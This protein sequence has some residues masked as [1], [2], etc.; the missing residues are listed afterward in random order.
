MI[1]EYG[2]M[3]NYY[4]TLITPKRGFVK[5]YEFMSLGLFQD[6]YLDLLARGWQLVGTFREQGAIIDIWYRSEY[7]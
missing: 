7:A 6:R 4:H 1:G 5:Q 3:T 2:K